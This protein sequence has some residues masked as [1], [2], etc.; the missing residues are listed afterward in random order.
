ME[1]KEFCI[2]KVAPEDRRCEFCCYKGGCVM[3]GERKSVKLPDLIDDYRLAML[4]VIGCD[5]LERS[6]KRNV[7]LGR[8]IV[9]YYL[10]KS[11]FRP[12]EIGDAIGLERTT[13]IHAR[14][15]IG[16]IIG[17]PDAFKLEMVYVDKFL[18]KINYVEENQGMVAFH[19]AESGR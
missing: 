8:S 14:D 15:Q 16:F 10:C 4:D 18:K 3:H 19:D 17:H 9:I 11:G 6:R 5:I 13:V 1:E 2:W 12:S 7:V